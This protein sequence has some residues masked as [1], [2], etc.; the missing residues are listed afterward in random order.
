MSLTK[1]RIAVTGAQSILGHDVLAVLAERG[2]PASHVAAIESGAAR[3]ESV[4]FGTDA[5]LGV[6]SFES[7]DFADYDIVIHAGDA[8]LT[9]AVAKKLSG[10]KSV[11][12][13]G[14]GVFAFDPDVPLV[15]PEVNAGQLKNLKKNIVANPNSLSIFLALALQPLRTQCGVKRVIAS[16]YQSV[17]HWGRPAQDELF[18]QTKAV[19][20]AQSV[21]HEHLPKQIAFNCYPMVGFE[22]D[23]NHTDI[24][25]QT[26]GMLKKILDPKLRVAV[27]TVTVPCFTGDGMMVNVECEH[28]VSPIKASVWMMGQKGLAV[29]EDNN[30][31]PT[32]A[33]INGEA[34]TYIARLRD[35]ISVEN[36][37]SFWLMGDNNH[38]GSAANIV[39]IAQGL[40]KN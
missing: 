35:D 38:K 4:S 39:D 32:H 40:A 36:G 16:T 27:N 29:L 20:M 31:P 25:W 37:L 8:R 9:A 28:E 19:F 33:D 21:K 7:F 15:V 6:Q 18:S 34:L 3:G 17:G 22:R 1:T 26:I 12:I 30:D 11:L 14:S 5:E 24:E 2:V 13:D 10:T 23:D